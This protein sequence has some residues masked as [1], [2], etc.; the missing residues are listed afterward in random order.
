MA[1]LK[2]PNIF[3]IFEKPFF[4]KYHNRHKIS[5]KGDR[6]RCNTSESQ[7]GLSLMRIGHKTTK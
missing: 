6:L 4:F 7:M 5:T 1:K 3:Q 2:K